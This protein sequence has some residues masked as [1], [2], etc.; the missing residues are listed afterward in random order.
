MEYVLADAGLGDAQTT[1]IVA[2]SVA[3]GGAVAEGLVTALKT[4]GAASG[5]IGL[6]IGAG[7]A[8]ISM[9]ISTLFKPNL[10][11]IAASN[12]A[13]QIEQILKQNLANWLSLQPSQKT[14]SVQAAA[15]NVFDSA[16]NK[17]IQLIQSIQNWQNRAPNSISDRQYGSCAYHTAQP[18]G[19]HG[20][21]YTPNLPNQST[22][23]CW[24]WFIGY[25]D[26]IANDPQV[27]PDY[28]DS[29]NASDSSGSVSST[30]SSIIGQGSGSK[31][32]LLTG[33]LLGGLLM[34]IG[35]L[36]TL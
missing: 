25:R 4:F 14:Q 3:T 31:G 12:D 17:Y 7:A 9:L 2:G 16:W 13:N 6:A 33:L 28:T 18:A 5:P 11:K 19:W 35:G 23:A 32:L 15:L 1:Q 27:I 22:G 10:Q 30:L 29:G 34:F 8:V 26:P 36:N 24:N 20:D 21:V